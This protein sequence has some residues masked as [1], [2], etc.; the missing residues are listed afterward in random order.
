ML[1]T[2]ENIDFLILEV[3]PQLEDLLVDVNDLDLDEEHAMS[4]DNTVH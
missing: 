3:C 1:N 4:S 2:N